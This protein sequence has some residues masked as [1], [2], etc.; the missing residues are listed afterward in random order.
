[1][2]ML[3]LAVLMAA[4][5]VSAADNILPA[6]LEAQAEYQLYHA[7]GAYC[8][9]KELMKWDCKCCKKIGLEKMYGVSTK[10]DG[11][12]Y[13]MRDDRSQIVVSFRGSYNIPNWISDLTIKKVGLK[14]AGAPSDIKVHLGFLK[15]YEAMQDDVNTWVAEAVEDCP[16]CT[17]HVTGHSM[18]AAEAVL[19]VVDLRLQGY[20]PEM[21]NFGLPRVGDKKFAEWFDA[22]TKANDQTV[23][24]LVERHDVVP[25]LPPRAMG[26]HHIATEV[27]HRNVKSIKSNTYVVCDGS[28]EDKKC[29][30]STRYLQRN[31]LDHLVCFLA[32]FIF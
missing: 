23:Y 1:M 19:C 11:Q 3:K 2:T 25:H 24:R 32:M 27:W 20:K 31:I 18:G 15:G 12:A 16:N 14:W 30:R 13:V 22:E 7:Y 8:R 6:D 21:W 10:H 9:A 29:S 17:V 5:V 28:G 26:F 4:A